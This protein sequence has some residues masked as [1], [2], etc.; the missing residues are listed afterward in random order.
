MADVPLLADKRNPRIQ[1]SASYE[2]ASL[3]R[4]TSSGYGSHAY[5]SIP[6]AQVVSAASYGSVSVNM[7]KS[8][9][10]EPTYSPAQPPFVQD[11]QEPLSLAVGRSIAARPAPTPRAD[12]DGSGWLGA[13]NIIET[14][15]R[16]LSTPL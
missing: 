2:L 14:V 5:E 8:S 16:H 9:V 1:F 6:G 13:T 7:G 4:D 15:R 11:I 12:P 10:G 3:S